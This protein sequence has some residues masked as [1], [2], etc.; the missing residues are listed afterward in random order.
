[1][2]APEKDPGPHQTC[3]WPLHML[4]LGLVNTASWFLASS[5]D[6]GSSL[7]LHVASLEAGLPLPRGHQTAGVRSAPCPS[8]REP[9][10]WLPLHGQRGGLC[11]GS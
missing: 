3:W 4:I 7:T 6:A 1:M 8:P 10:S 11:D 5:L 9:A 2:K